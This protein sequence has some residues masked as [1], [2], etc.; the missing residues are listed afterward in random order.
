MNAG[1]I[2][3]V[4]WDEA[5]SSSQINGLLDEEDIVEVSNTLIDPSTIPE[6]YEMHDLRPVEMIE[7]EK[8]IYQEKGIP[9]PASRHNLRAYHRQKMIDVL[10][11]EEFEKWEMSRKQ[12]GVEN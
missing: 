2:K 4:S 3:I 7:E 1:K 8:R 6:E 10:G 12:N 9:I 11:Q 5:C